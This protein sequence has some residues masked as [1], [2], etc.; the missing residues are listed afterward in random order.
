MRSLVGLAALTYVLKSIPPLGWFIVFMLGAVLVATF[1]FW[2]PLILVVGIVLI[3]WWV[4]RRVENARRR[5]KWDD[6]RRGL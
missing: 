4:A 5:A 6:W 3:A 2:W 1:I